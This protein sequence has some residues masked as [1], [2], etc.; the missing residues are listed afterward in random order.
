MGAG[1]NCES[2]TVSLC[3]LQLFPIITLLEKLSKVTVFMQH[4]ACVLSLR[5]GSESITA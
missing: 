2:P 3:Q 5:A 4:E 1:Q